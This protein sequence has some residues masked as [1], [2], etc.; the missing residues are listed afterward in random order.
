MKPY[1]VHLLFVGL[2]LHQHALGFIRRDLAKNNIAV[3][4]LEGEYTINLDTQEVLFIDRDSDFEEVFRCSKHSD[5]QLTKNRDAT[6]VACCPP[7]QVLLG[8][9]DTAFDCC[10]VD[11]HLTGSE[12][13]DYK[14]CPLSQVYDGGGVCYRDTDPKC[15]QGTILADDECV[16]PSSMIEDGDGAHKLISPP[17]RCE[18]GIREEGHYDISGISHAHTFGKFKF[19]KTEVCESTSFINPNDEFRINDIHGHANRGRGSKEWLSFST[20]GGP[21]PITPIWNEA[22]RFSITRWVDGKYCMAALYDVFDTQVCLPLGLF[23]VP[24]DI[25]DPENNCIWSKNSSN[26]EGPRYQVTS[27]N[28]EAEQPITRS[29]SEYRSTIR[30]IRWNTLTIVWQAFF[31]IFILLVL[32]RKSAL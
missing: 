5:K 7:N 27:E 11:C 13:I 1:N 15:S 18:S 30:L 24:C 28:S 17:P 31:D 25:R 20:N 8:N 22:Q 21:Y 23:Q 2:S 14:C 32:F 6:F 29:D 16:N 3:A 19:C 12:V 4:Q 9:Q 26:F 10:G